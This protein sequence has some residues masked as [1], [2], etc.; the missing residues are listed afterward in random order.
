MD[1]PDIALAL[2]ETCAPH[3]RVQAPLLLPLPVR[4]DSSLNSA[5]YGAGRD[6]GQGLGDGTSTHL[7]SHAGPGRLGTNLLGQK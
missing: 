3:I 7:G 5:E 2:G 1:D 6:S 4:E